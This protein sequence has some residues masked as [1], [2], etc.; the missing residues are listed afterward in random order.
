MDLFLE[1]QEKIVPLTGLTLQDCAISQFAGATPRDEIMNRVIIATLNILCVLNKEL[2]KTVPN[3][4]IVTACFILVIS[5]ISIDLNIPVSNV[6]EMNG[7]QFLIKGDYR[8]SLFDNSSDDLKTYNIDVSILEDNLSENMFGKVCATLSRII[9]RDEGAMLSNCFL[10][11][12]VFGDLQNLTFGN[13][14]YVIGTGNVISGNPG[15][16]GV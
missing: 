2:A 12:D 5:F 15:R 4:D 13:G 1:F 11:K 3:I 9:V 14:D 6:F 16:T 7:N 10:C 8:D